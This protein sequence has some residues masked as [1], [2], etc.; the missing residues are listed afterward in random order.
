MR[1]RL[2]SLVGPLGLV[3]ASITLCIVGATLA[4]YRPSIQR[5]GASAESRLSVDYSPDQGKLRFA[6]ISAS[7]VAAARADEAVLGGG[8]PGGDGPFVTVIRPAPTTGNGGNEPGN[9]NPSTPTAT[10]TPTA[11]AP[12]PTSTPTPGIVIEVP[13][14]DIPVVPEETATA[15]PTETPTATPSATR[16]PTATATATPSATTTPT[17]SVTAVPTATVTA[18]P[19]STAT[20]EPAKPGNPKPTKTPKPKNEPPG[21]ITVIPTILL[22]NPVDLFPGNAEPGHGGAAGL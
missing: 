16:T 9:N 18:V 6:R 4:F 1:P 8:E 20:A 7:I 19:T 22:P 12:R 15:T 5:I 10:R 11:V 14:A 13:G 3:A 21:Q 2:M 17:A